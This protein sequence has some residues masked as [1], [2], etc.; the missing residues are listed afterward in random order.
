MAALPAVA[1]CDSHRGASREAA[2]AAPSFRE[3][4]CDGAG[5]D[6]WQV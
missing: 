5:G 3:A 4:N 2:G 1:A 6:V